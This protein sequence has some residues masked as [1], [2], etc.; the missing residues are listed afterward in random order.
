[1]KRRIV[2]LCGEGFLLGFECGDSRGQG[3]EFTGV[4]VAELFSG[5]LGGGRGGGLIRDGFV[6]SSFVAAALGAAV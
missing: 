4:F 3:F 1:M 5:G 6:R 2:E